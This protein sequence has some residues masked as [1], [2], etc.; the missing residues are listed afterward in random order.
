M[1]PTFIVYF[2]NV[3]LPIPR[4]SVD[5]QRRIF[6]CSTEIIVKSKKGNRET[7][8]YDPRCAILHPRVGDE[9]R[10]V[11]AWDFFDFA[12][13]VCDEV[14]FVS[15]MN[16]ISIPY[17]KRDSQTF[18]DYSLIVTELGKVGMIKIEASK[19][20]LVHDPRR[21]YFS[22]ETDFVEVDCLGMKMCSGPTERVLELW[23]QLKAQTLE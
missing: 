18:I 8:F 21:F 20:W 1:Y 11:S 17:I 16:D 6:E 7:F 10:S 5:I 12:N 13:S 23:R 2:F 15:R 19:N 14:L 4:T 9:F 22:N 3:S